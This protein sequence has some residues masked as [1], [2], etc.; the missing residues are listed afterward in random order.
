MSCENTGWKKGVDP[1]CALMYNL[2]IM[3]MT[4][5]SIIIILSLALIVGPGS[6]MAGEPETGLSDELVFREAKTLSSSKK[7]Y[8]QYMDS[9]NYYFNENLNKEAK[10]LYWKAISV[11]PAN[12]DAYINLA[13]VHMREKD[14]PSAIRILEKANRS[15]GPDYH[16]SEILFYN[17]GLSYFLD[18]NYLRA[19]DAF[20][21]ALGV[22]REFPEAIY[23][24]GRTLLEEGEPNRAFFNIFTARHMFKTEGKLD[25]MKKADADLKQISRLESLNTYWLAGAL[26]KEGKK[27]AASNPDKAFI[28]LKESVAIEPN[29]VQGYRA[30]INFCLRK[31]AFYD[32]VGYLNKLVE[33][34]P[35]DIQAYLDLG[36]SYIRIKDGPKAQVNLQKAIQ[37]DKDDPNIYYQVGLIQ[38]EGSNFELA[39]ENLIQA[40]QLLRNNQIPELRKKINIAQRE[41][42]KKKRFKRN[43]KYEDYNSTPPEVKKASPAVTSSPSSTGNEG[44]LY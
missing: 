5:K 4:V 27:S 2:P 20:E 31:N 32:A 19:Q 44:F 30:L 9:A 10:E 37:L 1:V 11:S 22:H 15:A 35:K 24:L 25:Y 12:P 40:R 42:A 18:N 26:L 14:Y 29:Y 39:K 13:I 33:L 34:A 43:S 17:L 41:L 7:L 28:F 36:R 8:R 21:D 6:L 3:F 16:Q 38:I 23:Y